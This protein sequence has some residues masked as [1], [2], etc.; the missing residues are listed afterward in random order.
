MYKFIVFDLDDTL[1]PSKTPADSEMIWLLLALLKKYKVWIIS[2]SSFEVMEKNILS[3]FEKWENLENLY[4]MPTIWTRLYINQNDARNTAYEDNFSLKDV[5]KIREKLESANE[6]LWYKIA[7]PY[8]E[9]IENRGWQVTYSGIGQKAP[10]NAKKMRDPNRKKRNEIV[11]FVKDEL[12]EFELSV[13]W[14]SS[15]DVTKKWV[16]KKYWL[17]KCLN[18]LK[19]FENEVL[20]V[21]DALFEWWNDFPIT[22]MKVD[23]QQIEW[24]WQTKQI[25]KNLIK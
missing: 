21:G 7:S 5:E 22:Q 13:A 9:I 18:F 12:W 3:W 15:I 10:L 20:F 6:K 1:V 24:P 25:I 11:N 23:I 2:G 16:D 17:E 8:W 19:I 4:L 14:T